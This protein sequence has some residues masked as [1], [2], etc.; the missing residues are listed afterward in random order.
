MIVLWHANVSLVFY[1]DL[2]LLYFWQNNRLLKSYEFYF[3]YDIFIFVK[4]VRNKKG[5][6]RQFFLALARLYSFG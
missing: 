5:S 2:L 6:A 1:Q 3:D 4:Q